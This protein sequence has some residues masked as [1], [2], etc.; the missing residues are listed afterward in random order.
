MLK[1]KVI[2]FGNPLAED[3]GIG[4]LIIEKLIEKYPHKK[5]MFV[6]CGTTGFSLLHMLEEVEKLVV[7]DCAYMNK[8]P[9]TIFRFTPEDV[10]SVKQLAHC[11]LHE[12]DL[13]SL[14]EIAKNTYPELQ[15][16]VIF[17]IQPEGMAFGKPMSE[18]VLRK[19]E[20]CI[21]AVIKEIM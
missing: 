20:T 13:L 6:D 16:V 7:V 5:E 9:G 10:V 8:K 4:P 15:Q 21:D 18:T 11:S 3:E 12:G 19:V 1:I 17:G 14:I 2:G